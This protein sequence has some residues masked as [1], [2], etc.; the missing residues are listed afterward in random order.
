MTSQDMIDRM[1]EA[2]S[3]AQTA[4]KRVAEWRLNRRAYDILCEYISSTAGMTPRSTIIIMGG[5]V[6]IADY[7]NSQP[8]WLAVETE[9]E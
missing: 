9:S 4:G 3:E 5:T 8:R 2:W 7:E 6:V 1:R